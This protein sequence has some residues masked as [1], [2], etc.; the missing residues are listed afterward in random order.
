M[1]EPRPPPTPIE[2][3]LTVPSALSVSAGSILTTVPA[4]MPRGRHN[5]GQ[6]AKFRPKSNTHT[7]GWGVL[8]LTGV[9]ILWT[10]TGSAVRAPS[11]VVR[12]GEGAIPALRHSTADP[13]RR[14][15]VSL[16]S[17]G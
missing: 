14:L 13:S 5:S 8:S 2:A 7:P 4:G 9:N 10:F 3:W 11:L 12:F 16:R 6:P 17:P 1:S 15:A